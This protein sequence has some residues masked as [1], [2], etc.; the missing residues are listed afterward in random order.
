V[1]A[2]MGAVLCGGT[3]RRM[4]TDKCLLP[5]D[6]VPM[7]ARVAAALR[8]AGCNPV[9]AVGG[10]GPALQALGFAV[11]PDEYPGEGPLGGVITA[12]GAA[13]DAEAVVVVACD[14]ADVGEGTIR[15]LLAGLGSHD[16]A[17]ARGERVQ[18]VCAAWRP[19]AALVLRSTFL[20]DER[21]MLHALR[22]LDV[23]E[24]AVHP[25]DLANVN[26]PSDLRQ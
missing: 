22:D 14:L 3:S 15:A 18:P 25:Q 8:A 11:L 2:A 19:S 13:G 5:V 10:D 17:V 1:T 4:G 12:L 16:V 7:V 20:H 26:T 9:V 6:G 23:V 24:V 21:R